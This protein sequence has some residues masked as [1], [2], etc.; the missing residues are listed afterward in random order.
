MRS[1]SSLLYCCLLFLDLATAT[2]R[3]P[4]ITSQFPASLCAC[5]SATTRHTILCVFAHVPAYLVEYFKGELHGK[6]K[7]H[8]YVR[9]WAGEWCGEN[10]FGQ[11]S[12]LTEKSTRN[13]T[14]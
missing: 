7:F 2:A 5:V 4:S 12:L 10:R 8:L 14:P 1:I 9:V 6:M 13:D 11:F 3:L